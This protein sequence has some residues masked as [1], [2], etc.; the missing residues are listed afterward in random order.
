MQGSLLCRPCTCSSTT[1]KFCIV[2][3]L[4]GAGGVHSQRL[5][6]RTAY[7]VQRDFRA[8]LASCNVEG[9]AKYTLKAFRAGKATDMAARGESFSAILECGEWR[10]SALLR[11][12]SESEVDKFAF[13]KNAVLEDELDDE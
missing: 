11:Y 3:R 5:S 9:A 1:A 4:D 2:H 13:L 10:S 8:D 7:H 6:N 12:L